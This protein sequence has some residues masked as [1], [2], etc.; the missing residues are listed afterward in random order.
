M[1]WWAQLDVKT[2][3]AGGLAVW[4]DYPI[5]HHWG[6]SPAGHSRQGQGPGWGVMP[7]GTGPDFAPAPERSSGHTGW[8]GA[9]VALLL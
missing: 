3:V 6:L 7:V 5:H 8:G 1:T 4:A 9:D 2:G